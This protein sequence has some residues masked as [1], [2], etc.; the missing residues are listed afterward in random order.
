MV[1]ACCT[2]G[3]LVAN[4]YKMAPK[5]KRMEPI[6]SQLVCPSGLNA[7]SKKRKPNNISKIEN[8]FPI[9]FM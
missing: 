9:V 5:I 1:G 8:I 7:P 6:I 2:I 3:S 4:Q